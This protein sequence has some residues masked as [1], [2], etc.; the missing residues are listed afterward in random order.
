M[1]FQPKIEP[2]SST[3]HESFNEM[4]VSE[5]VSDLRTNCDKVEEVFFTRDTKH[6]GEIDSLAVKYELERLQRLHIEDELKKKEEQHLY[7]ERKWL[8]DISALRFRCSELE[9][10]NKKNTE[11]IQKLKDE[12]RRLEKEKCNADAEKHLN[13]MVTVPDSSLSKKRKKGVFGHY[14]GKSS[15][16]NRLNQKWHIAG[17]LDFEVMLGIPQNSVIVSPRNT[18][19]EIV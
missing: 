19:G 13:E 15:D 6:K 2:A 17:A 12:N 14:I 10:E 9:E 4:S 11:S 8:A 3:S 18:L 1:D 16:I 5:L 7:L